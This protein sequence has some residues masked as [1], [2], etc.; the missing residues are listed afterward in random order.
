MD[1]SSPATAHLLF[2]TI[3]R[4]AALAVVATEG[5][6]LLRRARMPIEGG[7]GSRLVWSATPAL[8]LSGLAFWCSFAIPQR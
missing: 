3:L 1:L 2:W 5:L 8:I 7:P 6:F 4:L